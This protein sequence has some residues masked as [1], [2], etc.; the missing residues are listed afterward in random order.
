VEG[1]LLQVVDGGASVSMGG[2]AHGRTTGSVREEI[3]QNRSVEVHGTDSSTLRGGSTTVVEGP[4]VL[5]VEAQHTLVVGEG[6]D[7][8]DADVTVSRRYAVSAGSVLRLRA[9]DSILLQ[10]GESSVEITPKGV[11]IRAKQIDLIGSDGVSMSGPGPA[12]R[13]ADKAQIV[14]K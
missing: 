6:R 5:R 4:H 8:G 7:D 10:S 11:V 9:E 12:M 1:M 3:L 13:L 14:S 2:D